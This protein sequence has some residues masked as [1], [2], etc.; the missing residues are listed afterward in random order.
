[1]FTESLGLNQEVRELS[2]DY[3][4]SENESFVSKFNKSMNKSKDSDLDSSEVIR[5][6]RNK[7]RKRSKSEP[8][9]K[10]E[11]SKDSSQNRETTMLEDFTHKKKKKKNKRSLNNDEEMPMAI[12][13]LCPETA[14]HSQ[15]LNGKAVREASE[16]GETEKQPR[17]KKKKRIYSEN[18]EISENDRKSTAVTE[19]HDTEQTTEI[20]P[21][22]KMRKLKSNEKTFLEPAIETE[23]EK[24]QQSSSPVKRKEN[25]LKE[26]QQRNF[27]DVETEVDRLETKTL[28]INDL[29][30]MPRVE[31]VSAEIYSACQFI[32]GENVEV[33]QLNIVYRGHCVPN[34]K[35]SHKELCTKY[36]AQ[37][38]GYT[39]EQDLMILRR[40][41][42][43]VSQ[44]LTEGEERQFL[45]QFF[46][47]GVNIGF[48]RKF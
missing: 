37:F 6:K 32:M 34:Q 20:P 7:K 1:M 38:G 12:T 19:S 47:T 30:R 23:T 14:S 4:S 40:F 2:K 46:I 42:H 48:M 27:N 9:D 15:K 8:G 22:K 28:K 5:Q 45:F 26:V 31:K 11:N 25:T 17:K 24:F 39:E 35:S 36:G 43:L 29:Y 44:V 16:D 13:K 18:N 3:Y 21:K 33:S 41:K 10:L